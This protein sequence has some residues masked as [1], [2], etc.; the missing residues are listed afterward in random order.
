MK[1][2]FLATIVSFWFSLNAFLPSTTQHIEFRRPQSELKIQISKKTPTRAVLQDFLLDEKLSTKQEQLQNKPVEVI[3]KVESK[4]QPLK[5]TQQFV[6]RENLIREIPTYVREIKPSIRDFAGLD[7]KRNDPEVRHWIGKVVVPKDTLIA[8]SKNVDEPAETMTTDTNLADARSLGSQEE[9]SSS[10]I[11]ANKRSTNAFEMTGKFEMIDGLAFLD[12]QMKLSIYFVNN[13]RQQTTAKLNIKEGVYNLHLPRLEDGS[14]VAELRQLNGKLLARNEINIQESGVHFTEAEEKMIVDL[15]LRPLR[16]ALIGKVIS[17]YST[18]TNKIPEAGAFVEAAP[19]ATQ[20][21]SSK[22]GQ[23]EIEGLLEGSQLVVRS[24]QLGSPKT[25][26]LVSTQSNLEAT[27]FK[28]SMLDAFTELAQVSW[29]GEGAVVWGQV[30]KNG[31]PVNG[32]AVEI[33]DNNAIGPIYFNSAYIPDRNLKR[34]SHNGLFAYV[35]VAP[36]LQIV[37]AQ[38]HE[39]ALPGYLIYAERGAVSVANLHSQNIKSKANVKISE[40]FT[41]AP[42]ET[43]LRFLG[44]QKV[45]TATKGEITLRFNPGSALAF[46]E[47]EAQGDFEAARLC[48]SRNQSNVE[49]PLV[50]HQWLSNILAAEQIVQSPDSGIIFGKIHGPTFDVS[51][52]EGAGD[53]STEILYFDRLGRVIHDDNDYRSD[54]RYFLIL[55]APLGLTHVLIHPTDTQEML[56][57]IVVTDPGYISTI[58]YKF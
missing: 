57:Q 27:V 56:S 13:Q 15:Q 5:V 51:L 47:T 53:L 19:L 42:V 33:T 24:F 46:L 52:V 18:E 44:S 6:H 45:A 11:D 55:N 48:F 38:A 41:E 30:M 25:V 22:L 54:T 4:S 50:S 28:K 29:N 35:K 3:S 37:R 1:I 39:L 9:G 34:T 10:F 23:V 7:L 16:T 26:S 20:V 36:G 32:A 17:G 14:L 8:T 2:T 58:S 43:A 49:V 21:R 12:G 40:A 31:Q